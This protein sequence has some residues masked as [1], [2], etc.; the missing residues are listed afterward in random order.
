MKINNI[1]NTIFYIL[2]IIIVFNYI[3]KW[4]SNIKD[5]KNIKDS[6]D[7]KINKSETFINNGTSIITRKMEKFDTSKNKNYVIGF[8]NELETNEYQHINEEIKK[9][10]DG[11]NYDQNNYSPEEKKA[12]NE[13]I[14]TIKNLEEKYKDDV[15]KTELLYLKNKAYNTYLNSKENYAISYLQTPNIDPLEDPIKLTDRFPRRR[16]ELMNEQKHRHYH[17]LNTDWKNIGNNEELF[18]K[19]YDWLNKMG[20]PLK[21]PPSFDLLTDNEEILKYRKLASGR[22]PQDILTDYN[23]MIMGSQR[24]TREN[25]SRDFKLFDNNDGN[26]DDSNNKDGNNKDGNIY[27][28]NNKNLTNYFFLKAYTEDEYNKYLDKI[29][30]KDNTKKYY[31]ILGLE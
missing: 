17:K 20:K 9:N 22:I 8:A 26:I 31:E 29:N 21:L 16:K 14:K 7:S 19:K 27:D 3:S 28:G 11:Y 2:T 10:T 23:P 6:K 4:N 1:I 24:L 25:V 15:N 13:F 12:Y 30:E 18:L 5:I